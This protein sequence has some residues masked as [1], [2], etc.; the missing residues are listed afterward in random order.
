MEFRLGSLESSD[1]IN[2][3]VF[4]RLDTH[5]AEQNLD[6]LKLPAGYAT[7]SSGCAAGGSPKARADRA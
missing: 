4:G 7:Q 6:L 3:C 5:M 1:V 2:L